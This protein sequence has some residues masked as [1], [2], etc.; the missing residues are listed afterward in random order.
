MAN[1]EIWIVMNEDGEYT[2]A[3]T[4]E[5]AEEEFSENFA[6]SARRVVKLNVTMTPPKVIEADVTIADDAGET[7]TITED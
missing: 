7:I 3:S 2:A 5:C 1:A 6:G 4:L